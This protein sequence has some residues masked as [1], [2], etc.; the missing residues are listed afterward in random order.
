M[1]LLDMDNTFG[2]LYIGTVVGAILF[3]ICTVQV[4]IYLQAHKGSGLTFYKL[5]VCWLW[6]FNALHVYAVNH[7][8]YYYLI[9]NYGNPLSLGK[10]VWSFKALIIIDA[11]NVYSVHL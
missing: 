1:E 10:M 6:F 2:A 9:T 5:A 7:T 3:G 8:M 11:L 4:F